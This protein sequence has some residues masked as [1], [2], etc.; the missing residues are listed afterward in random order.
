MQKLKVVIATT[1]VLY[2]VDPNK[3]FVVE[4]YASNFVVGTVLTQEGRPITFESKKLDH[5]QQN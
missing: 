1:P 5:A 2:I 3:P 4:T